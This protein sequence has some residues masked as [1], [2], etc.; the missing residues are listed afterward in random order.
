MEQAFLGL[1]VGLEVPVSEEAE[2]TATPGHCQVFITQ[3]EGL[4][5]GEGQGYA[6]AMT[7]H[8]GWTARESPCGFCLCITSSGENAQNAVNTW[9]SILGD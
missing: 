6:P 3:G 7:D 4:L 2:P 9:N 1:R 8:R 5:H